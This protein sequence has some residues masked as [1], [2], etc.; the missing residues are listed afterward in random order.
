MLRT[1]HSHKCFKTWASA[2]HTKSTVR[3]AYCRTLYQYEDTCFLCLQE[4]TK[5][6][7]CTTCCHTKVH[8]ECTTDLAAVLSETNRLKPAN[9]E[10]TLIAPAAQFHEKAAKAQN[11]DDLWACFDEIIKDHDDVDRE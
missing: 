3:C 7:S 1:L 10:C 4:Y 11:H 6:L 2:S 8:S 9:D 5:K